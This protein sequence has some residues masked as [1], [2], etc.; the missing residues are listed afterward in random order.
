MLKREHVYR[1]MV[2]PLTFA[3]IA[4]CSY[5]FYQQEGHYTKR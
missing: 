2:V 1:R 5:A 4:F 3:L